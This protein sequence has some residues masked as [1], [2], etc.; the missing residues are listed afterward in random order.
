MGVSWDLSD[1]GTTIMHRSRAILVALLL[2]ALYPM[3]AVADAPTPG[4]TVINAVFT[5]AERETIRQ[6]F[7]KHPD[8][9][10]TPGEGDSTVEIEPGRQLPPGSLDHARPLP[11]ELERALPPAPRGYVRVIV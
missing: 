10:Q 11:E 2:T 6:Y 5:D 7:L 9:L 1:C 3:A 4:Q 8:Q